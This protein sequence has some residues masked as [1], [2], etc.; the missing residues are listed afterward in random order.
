LIRQAHL[1]PRH[2]ALAGGGPA[3]SPVAKEKRKIGRGFRGR[4]QSPRRPL[5]RLI[6]P[7]RWLARAYVGAVGPQSPRRPLV[8]LIIPVR[9]LARAYVG[10][11]GAQLV[12]SR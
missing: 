9:W 5:V 3:F 6:I 10:A 1:I 4:P 12:A 8:R 7:V 11:V 2:Y